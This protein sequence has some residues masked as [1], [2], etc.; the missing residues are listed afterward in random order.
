MKKFK[1]ICQ[2][3]VRS[4]LDLQFKTICMYLG[5]Q[6][7]TSNAKSIL[8]FGAGKSPYNAFFKSAKTIETVDLHVAANYQMLNQIPESNKYD[9]I[10]L[11]EVM[12][13]LKNPIIVLES[14]TEY[15]AADGQIL[16]SVPLNARI[17]GA[18]NDYWRWTPSGLKKVLE[19]TGFLIHDISKRG[20]DLCSI[21]SK[22]NFYCFTRMKNLWKFPFASFFLLVVGIP[23]LVL[24]H[25]SLLIKND[26][27]IDPLGI[28]AR[29]SVPSCE[30]E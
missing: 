14:L 5:K 30:S 25:I 20:N 7:I 23:L 21:S 6:K 8:D 4:A 10:L 27:C 18:P 3:F 17:H 16:L 22:I 1:L 28:I 24:T 2:Y 11:I 15:L 9:L 26:N 13:H 12:E 19:E 29:I